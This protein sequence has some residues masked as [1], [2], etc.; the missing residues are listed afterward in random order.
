MLPQCLLAAGCFDDSPSVKKGIDPKTNIMIRDLVG[1]EY[2]DLQQLLDNMVGK[3][4][5]KAVEITCKG[6]IEDP[7]EDKREY[8]VEAEI[9]KQR[10]YMTF[11]LESTWYSAR[12]KSTRLENLDLHL[13]KDYLRVN[14]DQQEGDLELLKVSNNFLAFL[15]KNIIRNRV[16]GIVAQE[17]VRTIAFVNGMLMIEYLTYVNGILVIRS[18]WELS[19]N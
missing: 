3:W 12:K 15:K 5:G 2:Q 11:S 13:S 8:D 7:V 6:S 9:V 14:S 18:E 19:S 4:K 10:P 17:V 16:G 1:Q